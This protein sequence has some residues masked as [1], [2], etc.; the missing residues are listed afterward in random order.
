MHNV[1]A[2]F[3]RKKTPPLALANHMTLG[4]I[5]NELRDLTVVEE[6][7]VAKCRAKCWVIQLKEEN[8]SLLVSNSQRC[9]KGLSLFILRDH[10]QL[11]QSYPPSLEDVSTPICVIFV[12]SSPPT[13]EWLQKKAKPLAV[14]REKVRGALM[15]LKTHNPH[16]KDLIINESV[17]DSLLLES[18]LPVH[19]EHVLPNDDRDALTA[20]YDET[21]MD[22]LSRKK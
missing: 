4:D 11:E 7:M 20:R 6:A 5:P 12:G 8:S 10:L 21:L 2:S 14:R 22:D 3:V 16:Y 19:V 17:L 13:E 15:W 9:A 18:I 1:L